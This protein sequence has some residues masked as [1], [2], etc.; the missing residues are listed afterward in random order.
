[1]VVCSIISVYFIKLIVY[2]FGFT[3]VRFLFVTLCGVFVPLLSFMLA[4]QLYCISV[5][6]TTNEKLNMHRYEYLKDSRGNFH[7]PYDRG[8]VDNWMEFLHFV[9]PLKLGID[10]GKEGELYSV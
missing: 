4:S 8:F 9:P 3:I 10:V 2:E 5:N 1:L 6:L 7:N